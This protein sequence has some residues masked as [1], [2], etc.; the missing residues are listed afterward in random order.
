MVL[1]VPPCNL[2]CLH[3]WRRGLGCFA[4]GVRLVGC[5]PRGSAFVYLWARGAGVCGRPRG[6]VACLVL[7]GRVVGVGVP[8]VGV[9]VVSR[10]RAC[11]RE[12]HG[13]VGNMEGVALLE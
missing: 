8:L 9:W 13:R 4:C 7:C 6:V 5:S 12:V 1:I 11:L 10:E 2:A 3:V